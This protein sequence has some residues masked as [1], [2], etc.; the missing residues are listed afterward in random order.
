MAKNYDFEKKKEKYLKPRVTD[1]PRSVQV[2]SYKDWTPD[3]LKKRQEEALDL[4]VKNL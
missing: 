4:I 3:V 1:Y 2:L